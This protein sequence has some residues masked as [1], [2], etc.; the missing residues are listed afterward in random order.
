MPHPY[1]PA[2][3]LRQACPIS[4]GCSSPEAPPCAEL[5][6]LHVA[7]LEIC[8]VLEAI[9]DSLPGRIDRH[10]CLRA[11]ATLLPTMREAQAYEEGLIFPAFAV[12][13]DNR[14]HSLRR[15]RAEH[16]ED[17]SLAGELTEALLRIGHG[18]DV[19]NPEAL[20]FM[21]RAFFETVRRHIAFEREHMAPLIRG[22]PRG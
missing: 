10:A 2:C 19:D 20:G 9:A 17:D 1:P 18:A 11:A 15:L 4:Q 21:L 7:K 14:A 12:G 6:R 16:V 13:G 8:D 22:V 3:A 5:E